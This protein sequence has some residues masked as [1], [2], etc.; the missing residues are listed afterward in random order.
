MAT[1]GNSPVTETL[2]LVVQKLE[3]YIQNTDKVKRLRSGSVRSVDEESL[4]SCESL[5]GEVSEREPPSHCSQLKRMEEGVV[6]NLPWSFTP[7]QRGMHESVMLDYVNEKP[8]SSQSS[9]STSRKTSTTLVKPLQ[10]LQNV[11]PP[12]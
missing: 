9:R 7:P 6:M 11:V 12:Q 5:P 2:D 10:P 4:L 1:T 3:G 8:P